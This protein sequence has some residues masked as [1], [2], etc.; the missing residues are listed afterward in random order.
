[1]SLDLGTRSTTTSLNGHDR[2]KK[3]LKHICF[4]DI[5]GESC[6]FRRSSITGVL[7]HKSKP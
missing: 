5:D 7:A 3:P 2:P 6:S 1:M 4:A